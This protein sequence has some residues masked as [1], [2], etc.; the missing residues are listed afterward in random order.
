M[1]YA[2]HRRGL[3]YGFYQS[4]PLQTGARA[5]AKLALERESLA[6]GAIDEL[7]APKGATLAG[8]N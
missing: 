7:A 3:K 4:Q 8:A 1:K 2:R 5:P 6:E